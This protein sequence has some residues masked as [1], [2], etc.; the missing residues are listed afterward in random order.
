MYDFS[1][2]Y[3]SMDAN[4]ILDIHKY[5]MKKEKTIGSFDVSLIPNPKGHIKCVSLNNQPDLLDQHLLI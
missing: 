5:L 4:N 3:E 2:D 1:V